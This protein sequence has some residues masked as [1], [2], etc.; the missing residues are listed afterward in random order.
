MLPLHTSGRTFFK[1]QRK[2][3]RDSEEKYCTKVVCRPS[4]MGAQLCATQLDWTSVLH[5]S[6]TVTSQPTA[7]LASLNQPRR[8]LTPQRPRPPTGMTATPQTRPAFCLH[9]A[10]S[11]EERGKHPD[12]C[13]TLNSKICP[14]FTRLHSI[15]YM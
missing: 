3:E 8:P 4:R 9:Q 6:G 5:L 1:S 13:L 11:V 15:L 12:T 2:W 14:P 10:G 7:L